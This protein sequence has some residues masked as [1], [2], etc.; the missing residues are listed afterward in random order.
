MGVWE[1]KRA[2][3]PT[4]PYSVT[5]LLLVISFLL[6]LCGAASAQGFADNPMYLSPRGP[7]SIRNARPYN[8]NF[9]QFL[10]E[11]PD[12]LPHNTSRFGLQFDVIN[13]MLQPAP[14]HG[15]QVIEDNEV[16]RL[17]FSWR[18]GV[19]GN[20]EAGLFVPILYRDGG[21]LDEIMNAWHRFFA[22]GNI[23]D[24]PAGRENIP[25]Y[26]SIL[27]VTDPSG[28]LLVNQGNAFGIG[29]IS[30][31]L[32]RPLISSTSRSALAARVGLKLPTGNPGLVL[33][34]GSLDA[35]LSVD[36]RYNFGRDI[37]A[38]GTLGGIVMTKAT[39]IPNPARSMLQYFGGIEYRPNNRDSWLWQI[40][41]NSRPL[42]TGNA[43]ADRE[44][45]SATFGYKR[46]LDRH[47]VLGAS[48]S[49]NGDYHN[50][51]IPV[52][53]NIGPDFTTTFSLEWH[54]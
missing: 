20:M 31:T 22:I 38:Y 23:E 33:G 29:D 12:I 24:V 8:M 1:K 25:P 9:L 15:V 50:Y 36:G 16:Q 47:L 21:F 3:T 14:D 10:P 4:L 30:L 13:N 51:K 45:I 40:D 6:G 37:I 41:G 53:G 18:R 46:V 32:K 44:N 43:F 26:H 7:I 17:L 35:G 42:R 5:A 54:H 28:N 39:R 19:C 11:A 2:F 49:E 48:F 27:R 52:L 34:S